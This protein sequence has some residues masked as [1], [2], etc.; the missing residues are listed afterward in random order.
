MT[1]YFPT[2]EAADRFVLSMQHNGWETAVGWDEH[3][4][5][6]SVSVRT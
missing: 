6:W 4:H 3:G 2:R 1:Y 5:R